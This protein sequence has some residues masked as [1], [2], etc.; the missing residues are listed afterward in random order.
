MVNVFYLQALSL[1]TAVYFDYVPSKANIADLPSRRAWDLLDAE[2]TGLDVRQTR[3]HALVVPSV[4]SWQADLS[5]WASPFDAS[6]R[7]PA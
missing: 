1:R 3:P 4:S 2:I 5:S 6:I 7:M